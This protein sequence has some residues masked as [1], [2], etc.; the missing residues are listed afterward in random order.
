MRRFW[1]IVSVLLLL[2]AM[3]AGMLGLQPIA[4][5]DPAAVTLSFEVDT[6]LQLSGLPVAIS[7]QEL[8]LQ[9]LSLRLSPEGGTL[10]ASSKPETSADL[11]KKVFGHRHNGLCAKQLTTTLGNIYRPRHLT[12]AHQFVG[13]G[14]LF[15]AGA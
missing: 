6:N 15:G 12:G 11:I 10:S 9:P 2:F 5:Q 7:G 13:G 8:G 1:P 4:A 3:S 14:H